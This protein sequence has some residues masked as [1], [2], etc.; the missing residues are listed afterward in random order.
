MSDFVR[1]NDDKTWS[2][3]DSNLDDG[4]WVGAY[5]S[6]LEARVEGRKVAREIGDRVREEREAKRKV[7]FDIAQKRLSSL[8]DDLGI[9]LKIDGCG[10]CGSPRVSFS[11]MG[12]VVVSDMEN[13]NFSNR[14][15]E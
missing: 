13:F 10:C 9:E 6:K 11:Y 14:S 15:D 12:E 1:R 8:L 5:P 2:Y 4:E 7:A 3:T